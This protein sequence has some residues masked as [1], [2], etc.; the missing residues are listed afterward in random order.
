MIGIEHLSAISYVI[1][2]DV[3]STFWH[4]RCYSHEVKKPILFSCVTLAHLG[5][6]IILF[7]V[8]YPESGRISLSALG[9]IVF[10][11]G[12]W[13]SFASPRMKLRSAFSSPS[14]G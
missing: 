12:V 9:F 5:V 1:S 14:V 7:A 11:Y 2:Y 13:P 6:L 8:R 3:F 4:W 10:F